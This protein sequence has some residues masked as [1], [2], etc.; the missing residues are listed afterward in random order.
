MEDLF[1]SGG[2]EQL[3]IPDGEVFLWR[4]IDL[5][6]DYKSLLNRL[7]KETPWRQDEVVVWGKTHKQPRLVAWYGDSDKPYTYSGVTLEPNLWTS[8][9]S[10]VRAVVEDLCAHPFNSVLL[11][12]YRNNRDGMGFHSDDERELGAE[13]VI[14]SVSLGETRTFVMK[15]RHKPEVPD[16]KI[17]LPAGSLLLMRGKTQKNWKHG[18]PKESKNCGARVNLTFREVIWSEP[19]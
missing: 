10:K 2:K 3:P 5:G 18:I 9:L 13:P 17:P 19:G 12:Y 8:A 6:A 15:H 1:D 14:A 11:N 16:L 7:I 4:R